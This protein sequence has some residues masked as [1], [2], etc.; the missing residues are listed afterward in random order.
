M[1]G[2]CH[3][4]ESKVI[5][6]PI[7]TSAHFL[8]TIDD[9]KRGSKPN[10]FGHLTA[11][12]GLKLAYYQYKDVNVN[13]KALFIFIHGGGAHGMAGYS[14]FA[15]QLSKNHQ[16]SVILPDLRGH[17][18]SDGKRGIATT[19]KQIWSDIADIITHFNSLH[20]NL[21]LFLGGHSSGA[22]CVLNYAHFTQDERILAYFLVAP[23][24]LK[25][26]NQQFASIDKIK[27]AMHLLSGRCLF[28]NDHLIHFH[29]PVS[30]KETSKL[31]LG[32]NLAMGEAVTLQNPLKALQSIHRPIYILGGAEDELF[33]KQRLEELLQKVRITNHNI[34]FEFAKGGHLT[35]FNEAD[36]LIG[37]WLEKEINLS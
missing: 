30:T 14:Y 36:S 9:M 22:G 25:K 29:Y 1:S 21:P 5:L 23:R 27:I 19:K 34:I 28:Q 17:G 18:T 24:L 32:Y 11:K 20:P 33:D 10:H 31:V 2:I 13:P 4:K 3:L 7:M 8:K 35:I 37:V 26:A 15:E 16:V 6:G 12:D